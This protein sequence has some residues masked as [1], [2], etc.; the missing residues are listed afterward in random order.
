MIFIN[1]Y[2]K[3]LNVIMCG[4]SGVMATDVQYAALN[5]WCFRV[6]ATDVQYAALNVWC[7]R[8]NVCRHN[9]EAPYI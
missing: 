3:S 2:A 4:A 7:F 5:V 9:P 6:M 8:V 1:K